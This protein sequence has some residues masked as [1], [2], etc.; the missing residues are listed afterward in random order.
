M[1][2]NNII[3]LLFFLLVSHENWSRTWCL[4]IESLRRVQTSHI[5]LCRSKERVVLTKPKLSFR[6]RRVMPLYSGRPLDAP[7]VTPPPRR[8]RNPAFFFVSTKNLLCLL[9]FCSII[10][11]ARSSVLSTC[12]LKT[13]RSRLCYK[14]VPQ[15]AT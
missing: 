12:H 4:T 9:L 2:N 3:Q 5:N 7:L 1:Y 15:Q 13:C 8:S 10:H 11:P 6:P 14:N